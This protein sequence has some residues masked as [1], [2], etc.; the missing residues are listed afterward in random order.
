MARNWLRGQWFKIC[1]YFGTQSF[2]VFDKNP[3]LSFPNC[4]IES[5]ICLGLSCKGKLSSW[6]KWQSFK[7][8]IWWHM[9]F[10]LIYYFTGWYWHEYILHTVI[11]LGAAWWSGRD[12]V[13]R[14]VCFGSTLA[15]LRLGL[16]SAEDLSHSP[17]GDRQCEHLS[18]AQWGDL[19]GQITFTSK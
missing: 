12:V 7:S 8:N 14:L 11:L 17:H 4:V 15:W 10:F 9:P 16:K 6:K 18:I 19:H 2:P 5:L 1:P 13:W 3:E